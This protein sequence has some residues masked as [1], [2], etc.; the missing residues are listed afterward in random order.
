[1]SCFHELPRFAQLLVE[2]KWAHREFSDSTAFT[3]RLRPSPSVTPLKS[4]NALFRYPTDIPSPSPYSENRFASGVPTRNP[5]SEKTFCKPSVFKRSQVYPSHYWA[6]WSFRFGASLVFG[7]CELGAFITPPRFFQNPHLRAPFVVQNHQTGGVSVTR[8]PSPFFPSQ[9]KKIPRSQ[10]SGSERK[11][12]EANE[13]QF[14][15]R[16]VSTL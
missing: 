9:Q 2:I 15:P 14:S 3:R 7:A 13:I 1:M 11:R 6:G 16:S 8:E 5:Q 4:A 10:A 12:T